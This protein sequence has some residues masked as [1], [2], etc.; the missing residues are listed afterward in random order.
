[1]RPF[2]IDNTRFDGK[3]YCADDA[4]AFAVSSGNTG[5]ALDLAIE[6][7][8]LG[9]K[10]PGLLAL[11]SA[12]NYDS[13]DAISEIFSDFKKEIADKRLQERFLQDVGFFGDKQS[14]FSEALNNHPRLT[15]K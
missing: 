10:D 2:L 6:A 9:K 11:Y 12:G 15:R 7:K 14:K 1:M 4:I 13:V 8:R 3:V 5:L